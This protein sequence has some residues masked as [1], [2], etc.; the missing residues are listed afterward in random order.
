M[1]KP[2]V[3]EPRKV[4]LVVPDFPIPKKRRIHHDALPIGLLK[5]GTYLKHAKGC[6]VELTFGNKEPKNA[7]DEIWITSLFTY[8]SDYVHASSVY[9]RSLFP[10]AKIRVGG[11]YATLMP[12]EASKGTS[13]QVHRGVYRPA[14]SWCKTHGVDYSIAGNNVDFQILHGMRGCFRK[15]KFCGVW[16][17]EPNEEFDSS[18]PKRVNKNH[19]IF[20]DNNFLRN[21]RIKTVLSEL[22]EIRIDG[23]PVKYESQSGFDGRILSEEIAELLHKARFVNPRIAWDNSFEDWPKIRDQIGLLEKAGYKSKDIYVFMLYNWEYDYDVMEKKRLKCWEW[24]VQI[25][26]CR[27]RPLNQQ[28]DRFDSKKSQTSE[29]YFIHPKWTD[30]EVKA[31][32][33]M[34]RRHNICVRHSFPFYSGSLERKLVPKKQSLIL[35]RASKKDVMK[36]L[37]DAWFPDQFHKRPSHQQKITSF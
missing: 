21:P 35:R 27:F 33:R 34:I 19:V 8:W 5:I 36:R 32:R 29:D 20:Y 30:E 7:P 24:Q 26:D 15:C 9:Y 1:S 12:N 10:K 2:K 17:L 16:K 22:A 23:K 37:P 3:L 6:S 4:L 11:I 14:E 18:I 28:Y 31:F 25:A 13:G